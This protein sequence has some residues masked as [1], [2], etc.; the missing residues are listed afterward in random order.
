MQGYQHTRVIAKLRF[1]E[2][3]GVAQAMMRSVSS[4]V[5]ASIDPDSKDLVPVSFIIASEHENINGD[6]L[7]RSEIARA[8]KT[9]VNK[10]FDIE[11]ELEEDGSY[12]SHP[13]FNYSKNTIVGHMVASGLSK[14]GGKI[15]DDKAV[16]VLDMADDPNRK[17]QDSL[18]VHA[19]AVLYSFYFPDTV[20]DVKRLAAKG[21]MFVSME[22]W[23]KGFDFMASGKIVENKG[24]EDKDSAELL[25]M[26]TAGA[27]DGG[28]RVSRVLR[29]IIFGGVAAVRTPANKASVFTTASSREAKLHTRHDQLHA[30]W[31]LEPSEA[32]KVEHERVTREIHEISKG[33][34]HA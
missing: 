28:R 34:A 23:F 15:L 30:M 12:I 3:E 9:C 29:G 22:T 8:A 26:W 5:S 2:D 21:S 33:G 14:K 32:I 16:A 24:E 6:Y 11:H 7:A 25:K 27:K 17:D 4:S 18:D 1:D 10:P 13:L 19:A 31:L 20:S